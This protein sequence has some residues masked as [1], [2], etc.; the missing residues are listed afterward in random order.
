MNN[1]RK[2]R[3]KI[4]NEQYNLCQLLT[5]PT[6]CDAT[7]NILETVHRFSSA[8]ST[9]RDPDFGTSNCPPPFCR[10]QSILSDDVRKVF[11]LIIMSRLL[12][13]R[14]TKSGVLSS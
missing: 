8:G 1:K 4:S 6:G 14:S 7:S 12:R 9:F 10:L 3:P 5:G 11:V 2:A 13:L